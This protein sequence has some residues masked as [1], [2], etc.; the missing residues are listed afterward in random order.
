M[1]NMVWKCEQLRAGQVYTSMVFHSK[2]EA[3]Q[4]ANKMQQVLPDQFFRVEAIL[5]SQ[6]WN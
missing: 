5:A 2:E 4:F 6:V 3:E 1:T